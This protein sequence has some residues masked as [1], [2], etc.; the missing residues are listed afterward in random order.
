MNI[1]TTTVADAEPGDGMTAKQR[2]AQQRAQAFFEQ[3]K[4]L[5][6]LEAARAM[7]RAYHAAPADATR[8]QILIAA[9]YDLA[10][11]SV[12]TSGLLPEQDGEKGKG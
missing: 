11:Q 7:S 1:P 2:H 8:E 9:I 5:V 4:Q 12:D 3:R 10:G 6:H